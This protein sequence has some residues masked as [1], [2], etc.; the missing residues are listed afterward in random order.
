MS[1]ELTRE[2]CKQLQNDIVTLADGLPEELIDELCN[3]VSNYP[4]EVIGIPLE[5]NREAMS[6]AIRKRIGEILHDGDIVGDIAETIWQYD[7]PTIAPDI[8]RP[9][10]DEHDGQITKVFDEQYRQIQSIIVDVLENGR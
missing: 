1:N 5:I 3:I 2:E 4:Q 9:F 7:M 6:I 10:S 8:P